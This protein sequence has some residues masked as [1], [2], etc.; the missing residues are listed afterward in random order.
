MG[1]LIESDVRVGLICIDSSFTF[2]V[3][4]AWRGVVVPLRDRHALTGPV[5]PMYNQRITNETILVLR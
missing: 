2:L 1:T 3:L 4:A 5:G